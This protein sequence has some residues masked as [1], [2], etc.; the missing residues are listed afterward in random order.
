[1]VTLQWT[2]HIGR[3]VTRPSEHHR[4]DT[5]WP[6]QVLRGGRRPVHAPTSYRPSISATALGP[7]SRPATPPRRSQA[8]PQT[9]T[10]SITPTIPMAPA[11]LSRQMEPRQPR[12][13][14]SLCITLDTHPHDSI[15]IPSPHPRLSPHQIDTLDRSATGRVHISE[16][17]VSVVR[18]VVLRES[19]FQTGQV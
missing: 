10:N 19:C 4:A 5:G 17:A 1:M 3:S 2:M 7:I 9:P 12:P 15:A 13:S 8:I 6:R 11:C 16:A 14:P 18:L